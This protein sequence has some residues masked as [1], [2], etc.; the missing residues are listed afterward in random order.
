MIRISLPDAELVRLD[1]V[2]RTTPDAQ[3]QRTLK[4]LSCKDF[5]KEVGV[6][7]TAEHLATKAVID[8]MAF[9]S[10]DGKSSQP[11]EIV[12]QRAFA[13]AAIILPERHIE[14]PM[15]GLDAPMAPDGLRE[16]LTAEV[17]AA[18]VVANLTG[19][20]PVRKSR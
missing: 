2:F 11:T 16:S 15:H 19:L 20:A 18:N 6:V 10:R 5:G 17:A 9:E 7:T 12:A 3:G 1:A 4:L 14:Y 13:G 8:G